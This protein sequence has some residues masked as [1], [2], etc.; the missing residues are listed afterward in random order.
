MVGAMDSATGSGGDSTRVSEDNQLASDPF[1]TGVFANLSGITHRE[2]VE[3]VFNTGQSTICTYRSPRLPPAF[4]SLV[5]VE[6]T[7]DGAGENVREGGRF[8]DTTVGLEVAA[9]PAAFC[10]CRFLS[11]IGTYIEHGAHEFLCLSVSPGDVPTPAL[12]RPWRHGHLR[13]FSRTGNQ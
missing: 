7:S 11:Y 1:P 10:C 5:C 2:H 6:D 4:S 9:P 13:T 8:G 12:W 3:R